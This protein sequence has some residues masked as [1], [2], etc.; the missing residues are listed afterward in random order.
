MHITNE[1]DLKGLPEGTVE[2]AKAL[3]QSK[4]LEGWIF[5]LDFPSYL[6]FVTYADNR[7]LRKEMAIAAGKKAFQNNQFNNQEIT[8][9]IE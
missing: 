4:E 2:A 8:L 9:K 6:P 1:S 7:A 3:A 5:T